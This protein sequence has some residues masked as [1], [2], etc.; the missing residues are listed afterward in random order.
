MEAVTAADVDDAIA[1]LFGEPDASGFG[2]TG[3]TLVGA[4]VD[5]LAGELAA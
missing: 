3:P 5:D 1:A 2:V 4:T